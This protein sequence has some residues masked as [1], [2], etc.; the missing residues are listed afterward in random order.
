MDRSFIEDIPGPT[1]Y[2]VSQAFD[3]LVTQRRKP[4][5]NKQA[6]LRQSQFLSASLRNFA[7]DVTSETPGPGAY[8]GLLTSRPHG[9]A[10]LYQQRF[11]HEK[12]ETP[13]PAD[14]EVTLSFDL[15]RD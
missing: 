11:P 4:P 5:R 1:A 7:G 8:D 2:D 13:G 9:F 10:P 15:G 6:A 14:Y 3:A 12:L